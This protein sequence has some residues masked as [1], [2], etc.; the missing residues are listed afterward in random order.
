ML[1]LDLGRDFMLMREVTADCC[2]R[3]VK[4]RVSRCDS[5]W[6]PAFV[7]LLCNPQQQALYLVPASTSKTKEKNERK[8]TIF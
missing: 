7:N 8:K 6:P 2:L 1:C 5:V 4:S 3:S